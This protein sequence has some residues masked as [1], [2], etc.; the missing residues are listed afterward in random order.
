[1]KYLKNKTVIYMILIV[2]SIYSLKKL[3]PIC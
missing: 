1:M 3:Y 2:I